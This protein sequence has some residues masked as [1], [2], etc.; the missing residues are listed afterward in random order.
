MQVTVLPSDSAAQLRGPCVPPR[1][2][3][4][5][6][7]ADGPVERRYRV[8]NL[9]AGLCAK[10][11]GRGELA[12]LPGFCGETVWDARG[13][14]I[15]ICE[16]TLEAISGCPGVHP[17]CVCWRDGRVFSMY[18]VFYM[19]GQGRPGL[20]WSGLGWA[21]LGRAGLGWAGQ[22]NFDGDGHHLKQGGKLQSGDGTENFAVEDGCPFLAM[23]PSQ[24]DC[25]ICMYGRSVVI[26][27]PWGERQ[28]AH[29]SV[30]CLC[31]GRTAS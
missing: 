26:R 27:R 4:R 7:D 21:G 25:K 10:H 12:P 17:P 13:L 6:V 23:A 24:A 3:R 29:A 8:P 14:D 19:I 5:V 16:R 22:I 15:H 1:L 2:P 18:C 30:K 11:R 31:A 28:N 9:Y 20:G